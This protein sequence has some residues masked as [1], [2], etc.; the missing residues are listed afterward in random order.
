[1]GGCRTPR[2][3]DELGE[4]RQILIVLVDRRFQGSDL[5]LTD[6]TVCRW[7]TS[8]AANRAPSANSSCCM[9]SSNGS[10]SAGTPRL[11]TT[12]RTAFSSSTV[13]QASTLRRVFSHA[14]AT[15]QPGFALVAGLG[16][17]LGHRNSSLACRGQ[18]ADCR[19]PTYNNGY[20]TIVTALLEARVALSRPETSRNPPCAPR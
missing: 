3:Q 14:M 11:R 2:G 7:P 16:V 17:N 6:S 8:T 4:G 5:L 15:D 9:L 1:M 13:P 19:K 18:V 20:P 12:P 10:S